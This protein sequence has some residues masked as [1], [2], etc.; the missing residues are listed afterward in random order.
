MQDSCL[1]VCRRRARNGLDAID[2]LHVRKLGQRKCIRRYCVTLK[3]GD[4]FQSRDGTRP[5]SRYYHI[6][7]VESSLSRAGHMFVIG[8]MVCLAPASV[9]ARSSGGRN[10]SNYLVNRPRRPRR[11]FPT[12][13][14][15]HGRY[16][17]SF[18]PIRQT[19]A[20]LPYRAILLRDA[21]RAAIFRHAIP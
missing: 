12:I 7:N 5:L 4:E 3:Y 18:P 17:A 16:L 14:Y 9:I 13:F 20:D 21:A 11:P 6:F 10:K 15:Q 8:M 19:P 1:L 2:S